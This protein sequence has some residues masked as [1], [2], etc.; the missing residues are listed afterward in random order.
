M[1]PVEQG[2]RCASTPLLPN[3]HEGT[4]MRLILAFALLLSA[5]PAFAAHD[6]Q[7]IITACW[8]GHDHAQMSKCVE[9]QAQA[10][11][12]VLTQTE[13]KIRM[14][15]GHGSYDP[16]YPSY[17]TNALADIDAASDAFKL[18]RAA[19]CAYQAD[20]AAKGNG[21]EDIRHACEAVLNS[22]RTDQLRASKPWF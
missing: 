13:D 22:E 5:A 21:A 3:H 4:C 20:V 18:Y 9:D 15:I 10:S 7:S 16:A 1:S 6:V 11:Q 17:Q 2:G 19:H 14:A 12:A 8:Q